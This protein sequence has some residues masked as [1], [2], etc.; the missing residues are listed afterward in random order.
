[1]DCDVP[2]VGISANENLELR[3]A[4]LRMFDTHDGKATCSAVSHFEQ[5]TPC[6]STKN[7]TQRKLK[8]GTETPKHR[9][10]LDGWLDGWLQPGVCAECGHVS[11]LERVDVSCPEQRFC[12]ACWH[13]FDEFIITSACIAS[14]KRTQAQPVRPM[15]RTFMWMSKAD[16]T[17]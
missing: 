15:A 14:D 17:A 3:S 8:L 4:F 12:A 5:S 11:V 13:T 6:K 10:I 1:M 7:H 2:A 9:R 16:T